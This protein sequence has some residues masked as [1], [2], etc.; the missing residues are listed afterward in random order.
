MSDFREMRHDFQAV[1]AQMRFTDYKRAVSRYTMDHYGF[2][3]DQAYPKTTERVALACY[4][5]EDEPEIPARLIA[6]HHKI[7]EFQTL[8]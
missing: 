3:A 8:A 4:E 5:A 2:H 7:P 6:D 1:L